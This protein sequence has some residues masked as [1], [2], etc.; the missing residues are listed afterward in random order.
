MP[1]KVRQ[2]TSHADKVVDHHVIGA[3][4]YRA[5][6]SRL[7]RQTGE[8]VCSGMRHN[9]GLDHAVVD[10]PAEFPSH[11]IRQHLGNR[12]DPLALI[13]M[14]ANKH[15]A[16]IADQNAQ[17]PWQIISEN[18]AHQFKSSDMIAALG[19]RIS[20]VLLDTRFVGVNQNIREFAPR[21]ARRFHMPDGSTAAHHE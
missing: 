11:H 7:P 6:E 9:V 21:A 3:S 8:T 12:I 16:T 18:V 10:L 5:I 14:G 2:R 1:A 15:R 19:G 20:G 13:G 4:R 17:A